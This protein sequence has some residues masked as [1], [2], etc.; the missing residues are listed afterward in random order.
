VL[1]E[2]AA[3]PLALAVLTSATSVHEVPS[4]VSALFATVKPGGPACP[5][6]TIAEVYT[7]SPALYDLPVFKLDFSVQLDPFHSSLSTVEPPGGVASPPTTNPA[8][9]VPIGLAEP[10]PLPVF[11]SAISVQELPSHCSTR[12]E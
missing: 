11:I 10:K 3:T 12:V 2:P 7:P 1:F 5:A 6:H 9:T 4:Q 8:V